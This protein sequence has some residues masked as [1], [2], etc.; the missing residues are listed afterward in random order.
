MILAKYKKPAGIK[1]QYGVVLFIALVALVV[2]S[3]AAVA[4][5]RSVDTNSGIAGNLSFK[6]TASVSSS[7]GLE[8]VTDTL[9]IKTL[10]YGNAND[11]SNGY[12]AICSTFDK[13]TT[14]DGKKLTDDASWVTGT[15]SRLAS[16]SITGITK[17]LDA[18]G[19]TIQYIVERM[20]N[21][22]SAPS[23]TT[24]LLV[25]ANNDS[26]S[27]NAL[28]EPLAGAPEILTD[29]P[30]YRVTVRVTGPKNTVSFIQAFIS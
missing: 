29:I 10:D 25:N 14:C 17:G 1:Q 6:Q 27:H 4:L 22:A 23:S 21:T 20:C 24:C 15:T 28:N 2:M 13:S 9:G 7:F 16:G 26:S 5:I 18:Y 3:L 8:N 19:N 11:P 12:Y 30:I